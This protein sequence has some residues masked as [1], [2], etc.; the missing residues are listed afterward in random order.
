MQ[1]IA[2]RL[3]SDHQKMSTWYE[4]EF[5]GDPKLV[6]PTIGVNMRREGLEVRL[7]TRRPS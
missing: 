7:S 2:E 4:L 3:A 5:A 1:S 6:Q